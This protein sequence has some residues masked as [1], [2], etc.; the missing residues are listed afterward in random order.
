M[1]GI[2]GKPI[3]EELAKWLRQL[4]IEQK[5]FV[6][7]R[8]EFTTDKEAAEAVGIS[9]N[10]ASKWRREVEGVEEAIDAVMND[11][12]SFALEMR[13][14]ALAKAMATKIAGLESEKEK[15]RRSVA[16]ELIEWELGKATQ[17]HEMDLKVREREKRREEFQQLIKEMRDE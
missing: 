7:L 10:T 13:R 2:Y 8:P 1:N 12:L 14:Q 3:S 4:T 5:R 17:P 16:T 9:P 6:I 15:V 11:T